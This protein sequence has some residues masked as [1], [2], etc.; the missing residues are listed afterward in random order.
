MLFLYFIFA[1]IFVV[2]SAIKVT[3]YVSAFNE[4]TTISAG[5]IGLIL[6]SL[7]TSLPELL[8]SSYALILGQPT[9][10]F[11]NIL[12]SN[13]FN[14]LILTVIN[15]MFLK[16][17]IFDKVSK[18]NQTTLHIILILN[19]IV[20]AGLFY[21]F[22][23]SSSFFHISVPS[24]IIFV[25]YAIVIYNS[26]K[27]DESDT[28][29]AESSGLEHLSLNQVVTRGMLY[30]GVMI[31]FSLVMTRISDLIVLTYP[32]I[33]ATLV[34]SLMLAVATSL[35]EV[36]TTYTLCKM[37]HAN[38]AIAGIVGSSL[39]NFNILFV[40]DLL[41]P[42][43]STFE[44]AHL[45]PDLLTLKLLVFLGMILAVLLTAYFKVAKRLNNVFYVLA[46]LIV[47]GSYLYF[48]QAMFL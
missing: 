6:F 8:T 42:N 48:I 15:L 47:V 41:S 22:T 1:A 43:L 36:V 29:E 10:A 28:E 24:I 33:G 45:A 19:A 14:L 4:K 20:L 31:I 27:A 46:S 37:G 30:V 7:I 21:P 40:T 25:V 26:Y 11:G 23:I 39:F 38:I 3:R 44:Q 13:A 17:R 34:G 9:M 16:K 18:D 5:F 35:P 2:F 32:N 12:G